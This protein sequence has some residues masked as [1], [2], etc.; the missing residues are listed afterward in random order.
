VTGYWLAAREIKKEHVGSDYLVVQKR[1]K[2]EHAC[3][4]ESTTTVLRELLLSC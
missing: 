2:N 1:K 3:V 4:K